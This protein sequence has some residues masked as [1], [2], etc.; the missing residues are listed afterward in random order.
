MNSKY[1]SG[2]TM[3]GW[4]SIFM[5]VGFIGMMAFQVVPIYAEHRTVRS[6]LQGV[7]NEDDFK[8]MAKS[9]IL[10]TISSRLRINNVRSIDYDSFKV[11][12]DKVDGRYIK[13]EY[14]VKVHIMS[15]LFALAEFNEEIREEQD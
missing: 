14:E 1:Q 7:V 9:K 6:V 15:N 13:I 12:N 4:L 10:S 2:A 5:M 11:K 8:L 3:W